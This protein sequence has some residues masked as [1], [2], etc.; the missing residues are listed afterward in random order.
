[1]HISHHTIQVSIS[2]SNIYYIIISRTLLFRPQS[3]KCPLHLCAPA[4]LLID[5][6]LSVWC[7]PLT[8]ELE[9][10][11]RKKSREDQV[12]YSEKVKREQ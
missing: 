12:T 6:G 11:G 9:Q 10:R 5:T 2:L 7:Q 1:M 3:F 8:F 4:A